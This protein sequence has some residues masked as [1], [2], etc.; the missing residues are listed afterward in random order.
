LRKR[1]SG[2][3]KPTS[4]ELIQGVKIRRELSTDYEFRF[5]ANDL[6]VNIEWFSGNEALR[7]WNIKGLGAVDVGLMESGS[8]LT[9][10]N[11]SPMTTSNLYITLNADIVW[12]KYNLVEDAQ[13]L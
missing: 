6:C 8:E 2:W 7:V 5:T 3:F 12:L 4:E 13:L 10:S 9:I 11:G 1:T